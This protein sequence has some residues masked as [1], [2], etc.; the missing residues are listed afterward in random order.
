MGWGVVL[1][2]PAW[3]ASKGRLT[4][5][6][7]CQPLPSQGSYSEL[8]LNLTGT[9]MRWP[10]LP[11]SLAS[12]AASL[13]WGT[14]SKAWDLTETVPILVLNMPQGALVVV[15]NSSTGPDSSDGRCLLGSRGSPL[16]DGATSAKDSRHPVG[17]GTQSGAGS[18][19]VL[20][21]K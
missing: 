15:A 10:H 19:C 3:K 5:P 18:E 8:S 21:W 20:F 9:H 17:P 7:L 12:E 6:H 13:E 11:P 2:R 4:A 1:G 16:A 14:A